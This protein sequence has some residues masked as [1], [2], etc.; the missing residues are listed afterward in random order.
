MKHYCFGNP[1][2]ICNAQDSLKED[3]SSQLHDIIEDHKIPEKGMSGL[4]KSML[5]AI[6]EQGLDEDTH[7]WCDEAKYIGLNE[8]KEE[9]N[10]VANDSIEA[11]LLDMLIKEYET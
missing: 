5:L 6:F 9:R 1:C 2:F 7:L 3:W 11:K 10:K 8:I 4:L